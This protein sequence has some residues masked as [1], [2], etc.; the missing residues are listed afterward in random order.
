M[1]PIV[2]IVFAIAI[3]ATDV[4]PSTRGAAGRVGY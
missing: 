1:I 4:Q 3:D 2:S